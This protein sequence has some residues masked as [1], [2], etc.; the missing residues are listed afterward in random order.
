MINRGWAQMNDQVSLNDLFDDILSPIV[1]SSAKP[2]NFRSCVVR[3]N[4]LDIIV[5]STFF[6]YPLR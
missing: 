4:I 3:V 1:Y 2:E 5:K 6:G